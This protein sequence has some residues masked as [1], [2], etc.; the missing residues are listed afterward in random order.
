MKRYWP[1]IV[2][3]TLLLALGRV[4]AQLARKPA[5][6]E[7]PDGA[8]KAVVLQM[9]KA[10][11]ALFAGKDNANVDGFL[12]HFTNDVVSVDTGGMVVG[13]DALRARWTKYHAQIKSLQNGGAKLSLDYEILHTRP[14]S[15]DVVLVVTTE[16]A[17]TV[18]RDQRAIRTD[19]FTYVVTRSD[20]GWRIAS[21]SGSTD[22]N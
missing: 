16:V 11:E 21:Q 20:A 18:T 19:V 3:T 17:S 4:D 12:T 9:L 8:A 6:G 14:L 2:A 22:T 10:T 5:P 7:K 13:I 1:V 15:P